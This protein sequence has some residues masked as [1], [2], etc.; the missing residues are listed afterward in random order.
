MPI[1]FNIKSGTGVKLPY[2]ISCL[3]GSIATKFYRKVY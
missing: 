2:S 3:C 1:D